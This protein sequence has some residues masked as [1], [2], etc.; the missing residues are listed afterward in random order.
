MPSIRREVTY[1]V[2]FDFFVLFLAFSHL[3]LSGVSLVGDSVFSVFSSSFE[4]F[5]FFALGSPEAMAVRAR[6]NHLKPV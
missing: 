4:S 6:C 2:S 5:C 1:R 3:S